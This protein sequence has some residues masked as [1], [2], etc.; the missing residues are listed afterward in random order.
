MES[1][2]PSATD[3]R[4]CRVSTSAQRTR[5]LRWAVGIVACVVLPAA[6]WLT[7][8]ATF[9]WTM[10]SR[11]GEFR[12]DFVVTDADGHRRSRNPT[13]LAESASVGAASLLAGADHWRQGPSMAMLRNHIDDLADHAC[14][15]TRA[16]A[17]ELTLHERTLGG[18]DR[19]TSRRRVC[20]P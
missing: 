6:S 19:A 17:V 12:I 16:V 10:Y 2:S 7:G 13:A 20:T 4:T 18:P 15:E 11:A 5:L 14:L 9:A 8:S 1:P 3:E